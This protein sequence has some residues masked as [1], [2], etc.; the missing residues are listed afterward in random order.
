M[1]GNIWMF[2]ILQ[3]L[4]ILSTNPLITLLDLTPAGW[5]RSWKY[6]TKAITI[7]ED[8]TQVISSHTKTYHMKLIHK[9]LTPENQAI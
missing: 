8:L 5:V 6:K 3:H 4:H 7:T 2:N 1:V 9:Y